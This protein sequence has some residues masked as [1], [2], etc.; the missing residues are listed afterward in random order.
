[1]IKL[2][3]ARMLRG[4]F[5]FQPVSF[6]L[7]RCAKPRWLDV[8][9]EKNDRLRCEGADLDVD[10][11]CEWSTLAN[12]PTAICAHW[13]QNQTCLGIRLLSVYKPRTRGVFEHTERVDRI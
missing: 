1:M 7:L 8:L 6:T 4:G 2:G 5:S 9:K 11:D 13:Q 3:P 12:H 10:G